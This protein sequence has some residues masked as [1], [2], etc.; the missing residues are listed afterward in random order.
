MEAAQD[1]M[2]IFNPV[3]AGSMRH[4]SGCLDCLATLNFTQFDINRWLQLRTEIGCELVL[5]EGED[6]GLGVTVDQ[7]GGF[8][9]SSEA[10]HTSKEETAP[11]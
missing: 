5:K 11:T 1:D 6:D 2:Q 4:E 9:P 10:I 7:R 3:F 8:T